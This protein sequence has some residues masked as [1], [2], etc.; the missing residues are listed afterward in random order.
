MHGGILSIQMAS[1]TG[2]GYLKQDQH[3]LLSSR[4]MSVYRASAHLDQGQCCTLC[5]LQGYTNKDGSVKTECG[6]HVAGEDEESGMSNIR[7][8]S[9][10]VYWTKPY[11]SKGKLIEAQSTSAR[12]GKWY[13]IAAK[14]ILG[15]LSDVLACCSRAR[16]CFMLNIY[17]GQWWHSLWLQGHVSSKT[18]PKC[19]MPGL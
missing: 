3:A 11:S 2:F 9:T 6:I 13:S 7:K 18:F 8:W 16:F 10:A 4:V 19:A 17:Q 5:W 1:G 14:A 15:R 12:S